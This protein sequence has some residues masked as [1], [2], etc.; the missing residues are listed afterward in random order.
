MSEEVLQS[1]DALAGDL[2][3]WPGNDPVQALRHLLALSWHDLSYARHS[4]TNG[5]WSIQCEDIVRRIMGITRLVGPTPW[6][7]IPASVLLNGWYQ[8]IHKA[9]GVDSPV[10]EDDMRRARELAHGHGA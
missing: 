10:T 7:E 4:A 3:D 6:D 8:R 2:E 5:E 1:I 9:I